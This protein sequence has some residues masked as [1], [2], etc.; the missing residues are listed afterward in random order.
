MPSHDLPASPAR[1]QHWKMVVVG[2]MAAFQL[3]QKHLLEG[4]CRCETWCNT[5]EE[6]KVAQML[7]ILINDLL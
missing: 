4:E 7:R 2:I 1:Q 6:N 5:E 3:A